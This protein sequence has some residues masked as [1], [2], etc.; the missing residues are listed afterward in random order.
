MPSPAGEL[1]ASARA[2]SVPFDSDVPY[3]GDLTYDGQLSA[4]AEPAEISLTVTTEASISHAPAVIGETPNPQGWYEALPA[5]LPTAVRSRALLIRA[6]ERLRVL[7]DDLRG[8]LEHETDV[9]RFER[10]VLEEMVLPQIPALCDA[11]KLEPARDADWEAQRQAIA[12]RMGA[13]QRALNV[14]QHA[15]SLKAAV[16]LIG[17]ALQACWQLLRGLG[18]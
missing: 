9:P 14:L 13:L 17:P 7:E 15:T 10:A 18:T 4:V 8:F 1:G 16:E 11:L 12:E 6:V 5:D 3:A 2:T